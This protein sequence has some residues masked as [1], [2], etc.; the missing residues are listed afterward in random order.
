MKDMDFKKMADSV[1]GSKEYLEILRKI[2]DSDVEI[3]FRRNNGEGATKIQGHPLAVMTV[4]DD[5]SATVIKTVCENSSLE[6]N[7]AYETFCSNLKELLEL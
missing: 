6:K 5:L 3:S 4:L 1:M 2:A 7:G